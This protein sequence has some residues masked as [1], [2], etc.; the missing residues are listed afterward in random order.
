MDKPTHFVMGDDFSFLVA[1]KGKLVLFQNNQQVWEETVK[2][3]NPVELLF[4]SGKQTF[5]VLSKNAL[6]TLNG[7]DQKLVKRFSGNNLTA[8]SL[9]ADK[10]QIV[11]GTEDGILS[12]DPASFEETSPLN[13]KLPHNHITSIR[14]IYGRLWFGSTK[15]AFAVRP[16]GKFD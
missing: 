15:G 16:D 10:T 6:Y 9:S 3:F 11:V 12:L 8:L 13:N 2:D 7:L 5:I 1:A 14:E 4:D